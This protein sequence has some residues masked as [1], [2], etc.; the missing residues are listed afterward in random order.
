MISNVFHRPWFMSFI[1]TRSQYNCSISLYKASTC[2]A[3][4]RFSNY[5]CI[6][7]LTRRN[8]Q[9]I[10][11]NWPQKW[12]CENCSFYRSP[13]NGSRYTNYLTCCPIQ[14]RLYGRYSEIVSTFWSCGSR[15]IQGWNGTHLRDRHQ[16][17]DKRNPSNYYEWTRSGRYKSE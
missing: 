1:Y 4:Q 3:I 11:A 13:W 2:S 9:G 12:E 5:S 6:Q 17:R 10:Y 8:L 15:S 7:C 14:T 16:Y